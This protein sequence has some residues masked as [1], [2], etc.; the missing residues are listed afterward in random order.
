MR[1]RRADRIR[2]RL[3]GFGYRWR[4]P[5]GFTV[6]A[7]ALLTA[8]FL[9]RPLIVPESV[10]A[11]P[12]LTPVEIGFSQDM[13]THHE[14]AL[15]L[16]ERLDPG[17][18]PTVRR[19]AQQI[20]DTQR[21]EIG[22][23]LGWLRLADA[24]PSNVHPMAWMHTK[25]AGTAD[26]SMAG[27]PG[28]G[29]PATQP[30]TSMPGMATQAE[31]DRLATSRGADAETLFLQLMLRHH[32]GGVAMARAVDQL[33]ASGPVKEAARGMITTQSQEAGLMALL[34]AQRGAQPLS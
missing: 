14:Q 22:T 18:D 16:V 2:R 15:F 23:M 34:L 28:M 17:A 30:G 27:M 29:M 21:T 19:L 20:A 32:R 31:L 10:S 33:L 13:L 26:N 4:R 24:S 1:T 8:G 7:L 25:G 11:A 12:V 3:R 9:V 5:A 6:L